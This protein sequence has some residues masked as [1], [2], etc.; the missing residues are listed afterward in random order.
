[1]LPTRVHHLVIPGRAIRHIDSRVQ[2]GI[3]AAYT[4]EAESY[5]TSLGI[6]ASSSATTL[7][8]ALCRKASARATSCWIASV[9]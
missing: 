8:L 3:G 2:R 7:A 6:F 4:A 9:G 5:N 1:M